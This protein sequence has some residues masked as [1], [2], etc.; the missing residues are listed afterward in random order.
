MS[1][2]AQAWILDN[3]QQ[4]VSIAFA[5]LVAVIQKPNVYTLPYAHSWSYCFAYW[6][7]NIIPIVDLSTRLK[8]RTEA[9]LS[10]TQTNE[11]AILCI[12]A[13]PVKEG[14][15]YG[16]FLSQALP[17]DIN[18]NNDM[19]CHLPAPEWQTISRSCFSYKSEAIP[20][21]NISAMYAP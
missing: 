13:Y 16:G 18:I 17:Y 7:N 8:T 5:E 3:G 12:L 10:A 9:P 1:D 20:I 15:A 2:Q 14:I 4:K 6:Q 21:I 19:A 11:E